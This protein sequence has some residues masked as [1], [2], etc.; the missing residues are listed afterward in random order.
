[1][2]LTRAKFEEL[3]SDL[4]DRCRVPVE[5]ALR[6][7]IDKGAIN[8]VVLVG[9][10]TRIRRYK[11]WHGCCKDPN[12]TVNPDEVVAIG[13][14]IQAGVLAGDVRYLAVRRESVVMGVETLGVM[15]KIIPATPR[16]YQEVGSLLHRCGWSAMWK[17]TSS[18]VSGRCHR[19]QEFGYIPPRWDSCGTTRRTSN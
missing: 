17:S 19:Q 12:Q 11:N 5:N 9:G 16:F 7:K 13:A 8:E 4:I 18:K 2:T 6:D 15:T 1:M 10:S 3:C 14:A